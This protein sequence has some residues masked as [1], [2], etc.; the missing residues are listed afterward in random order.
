MGSKIWL[1]A[2]LLAVVSVSFQAFPASI[3]ENVVEDI[4]ILEDPFDFKTDDSLDD[5]AETDYLDDDGN[6]IVD[7]EDD[8]D[9][10]EDSDDALDETADPQSRR[11]KPRRL[12]RRKPHRRK[13]PRRK[14]PGRKPTRRKPHGRKPSGR[15][16][17]RPRFRPPRPRRRRPPLRNKE[18]I[19]GMTMKRKG[20]TG[21]NTFISPA[22]T[23]PDDKRLKQSLSPDANADTDNEEMAAE[24]ANEV[25]EKLDLIL[26]RLGSLDSKMEELN[27]TV[28][29]LQAKVSSLEIDVDVV[30]NK[31]KAVDEK[32]TH[33]ENNAKFVDQHIQELRSDMD[34]RKEEISNN[35]KQILYF[36]AY[37]R[38]ENLKFE[39]IP[40]TSESLEL[41]REDTRQVLV[42]FMERV[43]GIEDAQ[44]VEFQRV[45]RMGKPKVVGGNVCRT[46]IARFLRF[47]DRER[48]L[49]CG[50]KLKDTN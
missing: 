48:V 44:N 18:V 25:T 31:Q 24:F 12:P 1:I 34:K 33:F 9:E 47:P 46:I 11:K 5:L 27:Q 49:K 10:T 7:W 39:E 37:S 40:E 3:D 36:E 15:Q 29:N 28:K 22:K 45:H 32:C 35:N 16:V 8:S 14:P 6:E 23:S 4:E 50:R 20:R 42:D 17:R 19:P 26:A 43:L 13:P 21:N 41:Q 38:R 2:F 30:K